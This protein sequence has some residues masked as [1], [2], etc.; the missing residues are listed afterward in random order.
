MWLRQYAWLTVPPRA[1][2]GEQ[3]APRRD[4]FDYWELALPDV[5]DPGILGKL[6]EAGSVGY[7]AMGVRGLAWSEIE[8]WQRVTQTPLTDREIEW[9]HHLSG[10]YANAIYDAKDQAADPPFRNDEVEQYLFNRIRN[11]FAIWRS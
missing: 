5:I 8:S 9:I 11:T 10:V 2:K 1:D 4:Y 6:F 7:T 3:V